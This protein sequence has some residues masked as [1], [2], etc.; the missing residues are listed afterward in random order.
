MSPSEIDRLV[1]NAAAYARDFADGDLPTP[2]SRRL[3]VLTCM[4]SRIDLFALLGLGI[5][6]A[7]VLRNAGGVVT[8]DAI[9]SLT[10]SQR[11]L[12]T[13][14]IILIH[15]TGCGLLGIAD[16]EFADRLEAES[17]ERPNWSAEGFT[18][19]DQDLR[20]GAARLRSSPFLPHR[21]SIRGFVYEVENGRLREVDLEAGAEAATP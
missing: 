3:A 19:L 6:E 10:L 13:R 4:D 20:K 12:G 17:G 8:D 16:E 5:G 9:R 15:H 18:D 11:L 21:D 7:H 1:E 14:E 2:P